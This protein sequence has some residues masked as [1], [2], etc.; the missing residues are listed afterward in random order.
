MIYKTYIGNKSYIK[1][2]IRIQYF[3]NIFNYYYV[4]NFSSKTHVICNIYRCPT[5]LSYT[6]A[7]IE[8]YAFKMVR[9]EIWDKKKRPTRV[10]RTIYQSID[11][12]CPDRE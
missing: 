2:T 4:F 8:L 6:L 12:V 10:T 11:D 7:I 3:K 5:C 1:H 9:G